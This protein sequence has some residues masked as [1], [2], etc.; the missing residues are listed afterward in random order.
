VRDC[1]DPFVAIADTATSNTVKAGGPGAMLCD[2][3]PMCKLNIR[4]GQ[5]FPKALRGFLNVNFPDTFVWG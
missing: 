1:E 2:M 3:F 4:V 5:G